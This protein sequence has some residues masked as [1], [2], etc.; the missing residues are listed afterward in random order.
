MRIAVVV[1][2]DCTRQGIVALVN[3]LESCEVIH[4][5]NGDCTSCGEWMFDQHRTAD[6]VLLSFGTLSATE[7]S[8]LTTTARDRNVKILMLLEEF[9]DDMIDILAMAPSNGYLMGDVTSEVLRSTLEGLPSVEQL[10]MPGFMARTL[11]ARVSSSQ[12]SPV[13]AA[14]TPRERQVLEL[15]VEGLSNKQI[16]R[17]LGVSVNG[18]KRLVSCVL[19]KLNCSNRTQAVAQALNFDLLA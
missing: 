8:R 16:A 18:V 4:E 1:A 9:R 14:L 12:R 11:L 19:A 13:A 6:V 17:Q 3:E 5:C 10:P 15:M 2:R 7:T